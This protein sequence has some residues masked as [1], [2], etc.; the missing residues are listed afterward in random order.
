MC[1]D[2]QNAL[3]FQFL[4]SAGTALG[5]VTLRLRDLCLQ[6]LLSD[7][8]LPARRQGWVCTAEWISQQW[9]MCHFALDNG[10]VWVFQQSANHPGLITAYNFKW[11]LPEGAMTSSGRPLMD[12][13]LPADLFL[14]RVFSTAVQMVGRLHVFCMPH[15]PHV[16][17][18]KHRNFPFIWLQVS[19][20]IWYLF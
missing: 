15:C 7:Q 3:W 13:A 14:Q 12:F 5:S 4:S 19:S 2:R 16:F 11:T 10:L 9:S 20:L 8:G 17:P 1:Q 6:R 18:N